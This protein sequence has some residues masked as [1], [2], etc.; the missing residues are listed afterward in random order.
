[1]RLG[2]MFEFHGCMINR[3]CEIRGS[4]PLACTNQ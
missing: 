1:M 3:I 4:I 2:L